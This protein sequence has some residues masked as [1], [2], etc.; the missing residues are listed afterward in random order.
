MQDI[1]KE[2]LRAFE[3]KMHDE[4]ADGFADG[5][6]PW[7]TW[8]E[9]GAQAGSGKHVWEGKARRI[10]KTS[11]SAATASASAFCPASP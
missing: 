5:P 9:S 6:R 3:K 1:D 8:D 4:G 11:T 7:E 2:K 10:Y